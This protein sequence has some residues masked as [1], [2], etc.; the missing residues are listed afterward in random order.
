MAWK[1]SILMAIFINASCTGA[2]AQSFS[3]AMIYYFSPIYGHLQICWTGCK[4]ARDHKILGKFVS[5]PNIYQMNARQCSPC[6]RSQIER[7]KEAGKETDHLFLSLIQ[8][9]RPGPAI[10]RDVYISAVIGRFQKDIY[11]TWQLTSCT[12]CGW[13]ERLRRINE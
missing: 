11:L 6:T 2:G 8:L 10:C 7:M 3:L 13:K 5:P 1:R 4:S 12:T 9:D